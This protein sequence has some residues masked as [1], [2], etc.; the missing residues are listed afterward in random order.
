[1]CPPGCELARLAYRPCSSHRSMDPGYL[2][3]AYVVGDEPGGT[4]VFVDSGAPIEPLLAL[5]SEQ[6][7]DADPRA[8]H[9]RARRPRR[10]RGRARPAVVTG[11]LRDRRPD[12][13]GD[14]DAR[15]LRRHGLLRR[16]TIGESSSSPATRSS[17]TRSAAATSSR[18]ASAVMD[19][20]MAMP[21]DARASCRATPTRRRSAAS[22]SENPFV[23]VWRG[24][25]AG[26]HR[27]RVGRAAATRR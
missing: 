24:D 14:P 26:G 12:D 15:P 9:A 27:A 3:N 17:R 2:S 4:A 16:P 13:R 25:R 7:A 20:Y 11:S 6:A 22:G 23:R 10:A 18:S 1:M 5:S 19:V 21:H 8:A